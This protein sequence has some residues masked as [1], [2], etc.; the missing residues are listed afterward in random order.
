MRRSLQILGVLVAVGLLAAAYYTYA[1]R[2]TPAGQSALTSLNPQNFSEFQKSFNDA[3][4]KARVVLL[5][6]PT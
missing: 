6:S 3:A 1:P 5:L 2:H 4:D